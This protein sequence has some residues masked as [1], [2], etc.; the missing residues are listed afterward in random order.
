MG[1]FK[2]RAWHVPVGLAR[3]RSIGLPKCAHS[4]RRCRALA[5][6]SRAHAHAG[7]QRAWLLYPPSRPPEPRCSPSRRAAL[8]P[9]LARSRLSLTL[10][11]CTRVGL[12]TCLCHHVRVRAS[13][14]YCLP[15][16]ASASAARSTEPLSPCESWRY[17]RTSSCR[18]RT[19][20]WSHHRRATVLSQLVIAPRQAP[21]HIALNHAGR[22]TPRQKPQSLA[23]PS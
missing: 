23:L 5:R 20:M 18:T 11:G 8:R 3:C 17:G 10:H 15:G 16:P 2:N 14:R 13:P 21:H 9:P 12:P 22:A 7:V 6:D 19:R 4:H 1:R